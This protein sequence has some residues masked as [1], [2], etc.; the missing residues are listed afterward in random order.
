LSR[1]CNNSLGSRG[2]KGGVVGEVSKDNERRDLE[3]ALRGCRVSIP[4]VYPSPST[5]QGQ[6]SPLPYSLH[7]Y[8]IHDPPPPLFFSDYKGRGGNDPSSASPPRI[9][10]RSTTKPPPGHLYEKCPRKI[11][12][13]WAF[14]EA[15]FYA[16]F[17]R[18]PHSIFPLLDAPLGSYLSTYYERGS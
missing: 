5:S 17:T 11:L 6:S 16:L 1:A 2:R 15:L 4:F 7:S 3:G 14:L 8:T 13:S 10:I 9:Y 12:Y 18:L